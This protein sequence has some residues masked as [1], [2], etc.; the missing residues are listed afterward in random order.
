MPAIGA[1][2]ILVV[3]DNVPLAENLAEIFELDGHTTQI[4]ASAEEAF[5]KALE[6]EPDVVVTDYRL[7]GMN[8]AALVKHLRATRTRLRARRPGYGRRE[9]LRPCRRPRQS[10]RP[11]HQSRSR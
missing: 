10:S 7:P 8:G 1:R 5:A 9:F 3:D 11:P 4:A 2:K 6:N